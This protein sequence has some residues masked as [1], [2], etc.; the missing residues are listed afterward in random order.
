MSAAGMHHL[1][2]SD[3]LP[4]ISSQLVHSSRAGAGNMVMDVNVIRSA[5]LKTPQRLESLSR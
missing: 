1:P 2:S 4:I 5:A 3:L